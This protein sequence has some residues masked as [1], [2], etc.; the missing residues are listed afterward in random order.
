MSLQGKKNPTY[1]TEDKIMVT[2]DRKV[3]SLNQILPWIDMLI[4]MP[5]YWQA[6]L[7]LMSFP[8]VNNQALSMLT[9]EPVF[10]LQ[11]YP[12]WELGAQD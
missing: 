2:I 8:P 1:E 4:K 7:N 5:K 3:N 11:E 9:P 10:K 6:S 12:I